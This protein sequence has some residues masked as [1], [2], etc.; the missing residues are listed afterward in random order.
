MSIDLGQ[1]PQQL[2]KLRGVLFLVINTVYQDVS[3]VIMRLVR[4]REFL[5]RGR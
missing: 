2:D 4:K 3:K 5:A 1:Y